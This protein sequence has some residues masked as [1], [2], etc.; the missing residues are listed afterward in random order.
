MPRSSTSERPSGQGRCGVRHAKSPV[1]SPQSR[2]GCTLA[3][4]AWRQRPYEVATP[5]GRRTA[6]CI[7][8]RHSL[9]CTGLQPLLHTV[10]ASGAQAVAASELQHAHLATVAVEDPQQP[11]VREVLEPLERVAGVGAAP[12]AQP[13]PRR[14]GKPR[15]SWRPVLLKEARLDVADGREAVSGAATAAAAAAAAAAAWRGCQ[16]QLVV[17]AAE[18]TRHVASQ[19]V[20]AA[21]ELAALSLRRS[22]SREDLSLRR[23]RLC[24]DLTG[25]RGWL[26]LHSKRG[27]AK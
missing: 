27:V 21:M 22:G 8:V 1:A 10:A 11:H 17:E 12:H 23:L 19:L 6:A 24:A 9:C 16:G 18:V 15:L 3:L 13:R 5:S 14:A 4:T 26:P 2:G 20:Q 25:D 7:G